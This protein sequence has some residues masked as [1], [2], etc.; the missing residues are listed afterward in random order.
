MFPRF[1]PVADPRPVDTPWPTMVWP[2]PSGTALTGATVALRPLD[3]QA[4]AGPL[5]AALDHEDVWRYVPLARPACPAEL[6]QVLA[7]RAA[8]PLWQ[9]WAIVAARPYLGR[10]AGALLGTSSYVSVSP[11]N[12]RLEVGATFYTRDA[13]GS[14]V[15][16]ESKLLLLGQAFDTLGAG[17]VELRTDTRNTRSQLAI[18]RLGAVYEGTQRRYARRPDGTVRDTVLFSIIAE[19]WP[20]VRAHLRARLADAAQREAGQARFAALS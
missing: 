15:N 12:A 17:R 8:R 18:T 14:V 10:P 20:A 7:E 11:E 2:V 3:P 9:Q 5:F 4:D 19:D 13:W 6:A 1:E 16:P